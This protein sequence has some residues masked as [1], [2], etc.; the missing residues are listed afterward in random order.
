MP[1]GMLETILVLIATAT[2]VVAL[3]RAF[4]L[5]AVLGYL[6]AGMLAGPHALG[7][8]PESPQTTTLA[9]LG[10]IF[11]LFSI[12]LEFSLPRLLAARRL[13]LGVGGLQVLACT[14]VLGGLAGAL[15]SLPLAPALVVGGALAMSSTAIVLKQLEEQLEI[16][17]RQGQAAVSVLLFQ[18]LATVPFLVLLP[19]LAG[20]GGDPAGELVLAMGKAAGLFALFVLTGRRLLDRTL[21]RV[22]ATR[23]LELFMLTALLLALTAAWISQWAGL[24]AALGAFMAGMLL[25]E[26]LFRHQLET[27]IR[28]FRDLLLGLFFL[29]IGMQL[30]IGALW[31]QR[32]QVALLLAAYVPLKVLLVAGI[33]RLV[34]R[35]PGPAALQSGLI[36][37]QAGEFG[38][39]LVTMAAQGRLI[40]EAVY[41]RLL[42]TMVLSMALAPLLVRYSD[43]IGS[44]LMGRRG[45][46]GEEEIAQR[47]AAASE[48]LE[49]HVL[50][51]G[52]GRVGQNLARILDMQKIP[53]LALDL[54]PQR[55]EQAASAGTRVV[56]GDATRPALL[57]AA[58]LRQARAV[59]VTFDDPETEERVVTAVRMQCDL[60]VL[61]RL[62][63]D[64]FERRFLEAGAEVFPEGLESSLLYG[65]Q[66]LLL[67]GVSHSVVE[68]LLARIRAGDYQELRTFFHDTDESEAESENYH[69]QK[70]AVTLGA[71]D[72]AVGRTP[73]E[74]GIERLGVRLLDVL[75]GGVRVPGALLDTRLR[76]GDVLV[77]AG[78]PAQ[79]DQAERRLLEGTRRELAAAG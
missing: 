36:L 16:N 25:G 2:A 10:V 34:G 45:L 58:G 54:D 49:G 8:L 56:F 22:A 18:D 37:A 29:T 52:F 65:A 1:H 39:L 32:A 66:M 71:E 69:V 63:E 53:Y 17:T 41:Q 75:R 73:D 50:I 57:A 15:W 48:G 5:S 61:V 77:L 55:L 28:P 26:T 78:T 14:V 7:W 76:E 27:D 21:R 68:Q 11:L 6:V 74:L 60:P 20:H 13:V 43:R 72:H 44:L 46:A 4:G 9:E 64:R 38:L 51:C 12:G 3:F 42:D 70:R 59:A 40:E 23:S 35:E 33:V 62:V 30:D 24:S 19:S 31:A 67:L 79:L 47:I